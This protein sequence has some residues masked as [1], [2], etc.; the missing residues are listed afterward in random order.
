VDVNSINH[1]KIF[2]DNPI[3]QLKLLHT[4]TDYITISQFLYS[5]V[6]LE[7]SITGNIYKVKGKLPTCLTPENLLLVIIYICIVDD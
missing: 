4:I 5:K 3:G 2:N 6:E 1:L 7:Q